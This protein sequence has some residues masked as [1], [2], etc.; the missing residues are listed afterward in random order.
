MTSLIDPSS[1]PDPLGDEAPSSIRPIT[2]RTAGNSKSHHREPSLQLPSSVRHTRPLSTGKSPR[3]QMFELDVGNGRSPQRLLVTVEAEDE[4]GRSS[5]VNRRLFTASPT[6]SVSRRRETATKTTVVPLRGLTDDEGGDVGDEPTPRKRGRPRGSLGSKNGTP[7][8]RGKKRAGTPMQTTSRAK[9]HSGEK[10]VDTNI[11]SDA[12]LEASRNAELEPT[13]RPKTRT[14]KT[15]KKANTPAVPS[16]RPTGR[17]RGRPRKALMPEEVASLASEAEY[18]TD[19]INIL[20]SEDPSL[21]DHNRLAHGRTVLRESSPQIAH[22]R[23]IRSPTPEDTVGASASR[24]ELR[25]SPATSRS[26]EPFEE[27]SAHEVRTEEEDDEPMLNDF[28]GEAHSDIESEFDGT[29]GI[30][31]SGQDNLTHASDFSMIAVEALP[32]FQA[33]IQSNRSGVIEEAPRYSEAGDETNMIINQTMESYRR[34]TQSEAQDR[35]HIENAQKE[36]EHGSSAG[37]HHSSLQQRNSPSNFGSSQM[38][39]TRS[40]KRPQKAMPLSRQVFSTSRAPHVDDSFSSI[41]DSIL[42][43]ATPGRLPMKPTLTQEVDDDSNM[44]EDSFSEI[45]DEVLMAATPKPNRTA[46]QLRQ[47]GNGDLPSS[48][49]EVQSASRSTNIGSD[50]LPTPDDTNSSTTDAKNGHGD[51]TMRMEGDSSAVVPTSDLNI[52]SSPPTI[53]RQF[54]TMNL[55]PESAHTVSRHFD[56]MAIQSEASQAEQTRA[57]TPPRK[58]SSPQ[59]QL[60]KSKS[61]DQSQSLHPP[62][63]SRRPTLSPIVRAG[64]T[65]QNI[66]SDRSSP[67]DHGSLGSPFRGSAHNDSRQSSVAKSPARESNHRRTGSDSRLFFN[68]TASLSQSIRSAFGS[69]QQA[70]LVS[71]SAPTGDPLFGEVKDPFGLD[72]HDYSQTMALRR[73]AYSIETIPANLQPGQ[74]DIPP[75]VPSSARAAPLS[76]QGSHLEV[77]SVVG[78]EDPSSPATQR[79]RR[80]SLSQRSANLSIF[81]ARASQTSRLHDVTNAQEDNQ[82]DEIEKGEDVIDG[83]GHDDQSQRDEAE[84]FEAAQLGDEQSEDDQVEDEPEDGESQGEQL[85]DE[86]AMNSSEADDVD[87]DIWDF[88]ASRATPRSTKALRAEARSRRQSHIEAHA[89]PVSPALSDVANSTV[90]VAAEPEPPRR[91]K[92]PSPWRRN[93]RRLIYQDDFRSPSEIAIEDS[94]PSDA[95]RATLIPRAVVQQ[96]QS[97]E[98]SSLMPQEVAQRIEEQEEAAGNR[99]EV[100]ENFEDNGLYDLM[101]YDEPLEPEDL[102]PEPEQQKSDTPFA[103]HSEPQEYSM[104]SH[105]DK[106]P[107]MAQEKQEPPVPARKSFFGNFDILS[108]FSSPRPPPIANDVPRT[109]VDETPLHRIITKPPPR[110][111]QSIDKSLIE[112][113]RSALRAAGLFPSIRQKIFNPSPQRRVDLFS[114]GTALRS[115]DTVADTYAET[116]STPAR[117]EFPSI[118][119]KRNFTPLSV[120]SRN[121]ESLFTPSRQGS[122]PAQH[123][124]TPSPEHDDLEE[125][126]HSGDEDTIL[127]EGPSFEMIPPREKPSQ[128]DKT[129]SP[130]KSSFRSP[131]KPK[132]PGRV[133]VFTNSVLSPEAQEQVCTERQRALNAVSIGSVNIATNN[134][135]TAILNPSPLRVPASYQSHDQDKE[136]TPS[137]PKSPERQTVQPIQSARVQSIAPAGLSSVAWS[138]A[139][140][141]RLDEI[142]QLRKR[143]PMQFQMVFPSVPPGKHPLFGLEVATQD[144]KLVLEDWHLEVVE[145]FRSELAIGPRPLS[146]NGATQNVWDAKSLSKRLFA[147]MVGEERRRSGKYASSQPKKGA[148]GKGKDRETAFSTS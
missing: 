105:Y 108:F 147:L 137:P 81:G 75:E 72:L 127:T 139:H 82:V 56:T 131:I 123:V 120:Q 50:R 38:S 119:Q 27:A 12:L 25:R 14:R 124:R 22:A 138:R 10:T 126:D 6:R 2:R 34:S 8:P 44:Y 4:R 51:R 48:E 77:S 101:E 47:D 9:R 100:E 84:D 19:S 109:E 129:L 39:W 80:I 115:N 74:P 36:T 134:P 93:N 21:E 99:E 86:T 52:R 143:D 135:R 40:P 23:S 53:S 29:D 116:P 95:D 20:P 96:E 17:K 78:N 1:S 30:T 59:M 90:P 66:M 16:S 88:E 85:G 33:S 63:Q 70:A 60:T 130:I 45:P 106:S 92:I 35:S 64:R 140:W 125:L 141:I 57:D 46:D 91:S 55:Q 58:S 145:A 112:E 71:A 104:V 61:P 32:S 118:P 107:E 62:A 146:G 133:V 122:T 49:G 136:N 15:P 18:R 26:P 68:P 87:M 11:P 98:R 103:L 76:E 142:L 110:S 7:A 89:P 5:G 69:A 113:P 42:R 54:N 79:S 3:K 97:V 67:D 144:A 37:S 13:P 83:I 31:Y 132:T 102:S 121:T 114:P 94:P 65:L 117:Q 73:S 28:T 24:S 43:A 41:P 148:R 111:V 128:W